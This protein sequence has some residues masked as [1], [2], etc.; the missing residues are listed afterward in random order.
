MSF[1]SNSNLKPALILAG[2]YEF[3]NLQVSAAG[4]YLYKAICDAPYDASIQ[5]GAF[6]VQDM[7][8]RFTSQPSSM[9]RAMTPFSVSLSFW[10]PVSM[11]LASAAPLPSGVS[12]Q[13]KLSDGTVLATDT[14]SDTSKTCLILKLN[15]F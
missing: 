15:S 6:I 4:A 11:A 7:E 3:T 2:N 8:I 12:C 13:L 14:M 1:H 5:T 10:D 9:I